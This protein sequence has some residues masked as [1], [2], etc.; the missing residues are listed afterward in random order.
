MTKDQQVDTDTAAAEVLNYKWACPECGATDWLAVVVLAWAELIQHEDGEWET[1]VTGERP[2]HD[3]EFTESSL[4]QCKECGHCDK[5][6]AFD[7]EKGV[8]DDNH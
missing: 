3:V 2:D 1:D 4:M 6:Q 8:S 7:T 5:S